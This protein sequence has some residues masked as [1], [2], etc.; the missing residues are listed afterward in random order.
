MVGLWE[1]L[2][3]EIDGFKIMTIPDLETFLV[4]EKVE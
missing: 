1:N 3:P 2:R 4:D